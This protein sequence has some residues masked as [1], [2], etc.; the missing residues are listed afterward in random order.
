MNGKQVAQTFVV[1]VCGLYSSK[2]NLEEK[3]RTW[4]SPVR[5]TG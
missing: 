4:E 2:K 5:A 1:K 3:P